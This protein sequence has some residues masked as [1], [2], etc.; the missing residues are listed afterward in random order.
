MARVLI[1]HCFR[2]MP[3][4]WIYVCL[5]L[6]GDRE[7]KRITLPGQTNQVWHGYLPNLDPGALY[8]YR[9]YGPYE[10]DRGHRF[11]HHKLLLDP[12]A[13]SIKGKLEYCDSHLAYDK[14]SNDVDLSFSEVDSA[15]VMPKCVL[16]GAES[17]GQSP[18]KPG[19]RWSETIIYETHVR[20]F[21]VTHPDIEQHLRGTFD[22]MA[23]PQIIQYL[24]A[25]GITTVELLP[26]QAFADEGFLL[27]KGL[28]NY[29]GYNSLSFFTPEPRYLSSGK[30]DE[31]RHM[32]D[33]FHDSGIEVILDVVYN[34]TAEGDQLG[35]TYCYRG[36]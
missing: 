17:F 10:P 33:R 28:T 34:H 14:H 29:W 4:G 1:L 8:G 31:F 3:R 20:G 6:Q 16:H 5:M 18:D 2:R 26:I 21:T 30:V 19:V 9:V 32:V 35:P 12:Y 24:K 11:N 22:G 13:R 27:S 25:L 15:P 23:Q 7:L 36:N